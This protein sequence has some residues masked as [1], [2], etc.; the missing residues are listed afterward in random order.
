MLKRIVLSLSFSIVSLSY[1]NAFADSKQL[2]MGGVG[3]DIPVLNQGNFGT[4]ATFAGTAFLSAE[5][6]LYGDDMIS[7]LCH[8]QVSRA[9]PGINWCHTT[10]GSDCHGLGAWAGS[11][12]GQNVLE[13]ISQYGYMSMNDQ[14]IYL[15]GT[16][17]GVY[18]FGTN[19]VPGNPIS[20]ST[21][22]LTQKFTQHNVVDSSQMWGENKITETKQQL[23]NGHRILIGSLI[24]KDHN[25]YDYI[26]GYYKNIMDG[27]VLSPTISAR[28]KVQDKNYAGHEMI[29]TGYDDDACITVKDASGKDY[30]PTYTNDSGQ[31]VEDRG[32]FTLRNSWGNGVGDSGTY[33][34]SYEYYRFF[35][36]E[37]IYI[38]K[39]GVSAS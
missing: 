3:G 24:Y 10:D 20:V 16:S 25:G 17:D 35:V 14:K 6:G 38:D 31:N 19:A 37:A 9:S 26:D 30:C 28:L 12:N 27:W 18:P 34:M 32:V 36:Y 33:Y 15:C 2:G 11:T 13:Q 23:K 21:F 1:L 8:L 39:A 4:C 7:P 5:L 29:I 22:H